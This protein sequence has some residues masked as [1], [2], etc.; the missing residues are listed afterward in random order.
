M[1]DSTNIVTAKTDEPDF[2][3]LGQVSSDVEKWYSNALAVIKLRSKGATKVSKLPKGV[4]R[5]IIEYQFP[6]EL[7]W[8]Y[9]DPYMPI[10]EKQDRHFPT[11]DKLDYRNYLVAINEVPEW[12][13]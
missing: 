1:V 5:C 11:I 6:I 4:F 3:C 10:N 7:S 13:Y 8:R 2:I 12:E 9:S